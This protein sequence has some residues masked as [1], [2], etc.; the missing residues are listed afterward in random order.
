MADSLI[1][2]A[3]ALEGVTGA[4]ADFA[5]SIYH[6]ESSSGTNTQTSNAG[7][8][9]GMQI[10]PSTFRSVA[11][12]G[13]NIA[14]PLQNIRA[15]IRYA[16]KMFNAAKGDP[17]IAAAGYYGGLGGL[18][19]AKKGIAVKDPKNP[20][21]PSTLEY[22]QQVAGRMGGG[23]SGEQ[24]LAALQSE[25][26]ELTAAP[27]QSAPDMAK[28]FSA[29]KAGKM[30]K[31]DAT[32]F[33]QD[34]NA[35][36]IM[37]PV[38]GQL[39]AGAA[40]KE[41]PVIDAQVVAARNQGLM[42]EEDAL[43]FDADIKAGII[44][45]P[46]GAAYPTPKTAAPQEAQPTTL[47]GDVGQGF[48]NLGGAIV[49]DGG[50]V[51]VF[52]APTR[53]G[54]GAAEAIVGGGAH[55]AA[56]VPEGLY[57]ITNGI[58]NMLPKAI[59]GGGSSFGEGYTYGAQQVKNLA[60]K[61]IPPPLTKAG[62]AI[63]QIMGA[64]GAEL[65]RGG[66]GAGAWVEDKTGSKVAGGLAASLFETAGNA[67][68]M[69]LPLKGR[70]ASQNAA[71]A[72]RTRQQIIDSQ[73]A[74]QPAPTPAPIP[75]PAPVRTPAE[76]MDADIAA[77]Q[78]ER[79]AQQPLAAS[80]EGLAAQAETMQAPAVEVGKPAIHS[81][82]GVETPVVVKNIEQAVSDGKTYARVEHEGGVSVVPVEELSPVAAKAQPSEPVTPKIEEIATPIPEITRPDGKTYVLDDSLDLV[83]GSSK[84]D[85]S[86]DTLQITGR[87]DAKQSKRGRSFGGFYLTSLADEAQAAGYSRMGDGT[88]TLYDVR[89]KPDTKIL[90]KTGDIM[91][92]DDNYIN[93][94]VN[95]GYGLI[96]GKD[97]RGRTE[98]VVL[99]KNAVEGM[100]A[101]SEAAP[102]PL[103][104]PPTPRPVPEPVP[105]IPEPAPIPAPRPIPEVIPDGAADAAGL[106]LQELAS[107][108]R[109]SSES[110]FG[111]N[112][113]KEALAEQVALDPK[114]VAAAER[115]GVI[116]E[117]MPEHLTT[118]QSYREL[119]QAIK[120]YTGSALGA[121]DKQRLSVVAA[122]ADKIIEDIGATKDISSLSQ[123]IKDHM[124][125][126]IE[127]LKSRA[128]SMY[129]SL[130]EKI[131]QTDQVAAPETMAFIDERVRTMNGAQ[132]ITKYE[133][134][135]QAKLSDKSK[136]TYARLDDVRRELTAAK[137]KKEGSFGEADSWMIDQLLTR[138]NKD[139]RTAIETLATRNGL[140]G[141]AL[142]AEF[143]L[144]QQTAGLYK[145]VQ[146]DMVRLFG[147]QL[148]GNIASALK[149][150]VAGLARGDIKAFANLIKAIPESMRSEVVANGLA[151]AFDKNLGAINYNT[152]ANFWN[153]IKRQGEA[154]KLLK[155]YLPE[156]SYKALD[157]LGIVSES[158]AKSLKEN[159]QTGKIN[160]VTE[161]L[162]DADTM[163]GKLYEKAK[164]GAVQAA[165]TEAI[166]TAAGFP[167]AGIAI[168]AVLALSKNKAPIHLAVENVIGSKEFRDAVFAKSNIEARR[169]QQ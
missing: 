31:D 15:G 83:H 158:I 89:I 51:D 45:L 44:A 78:A 62:E 93:Q 74:R 16:T 10:T 69:G 129:D 54:F 98:Y 157:D 138:L 111:K 13:W 132:H 104:V 21:A 64:P 33:E 40:L 81:A 50:F 130:R 59:G 3:L 131:Q 103:P 100:A 66:Q 82:N 88:P 105:P 153:G 71:A 11:D 38:G 136:P 39:K 7:A 112:T 154:N 70:A 108:A 46:N 114:V 163:I 156:Q 24:S 67:A 150:G 126:T 30:T 42:S 113:A 9:G 2:K 32:S 65:H 133:K 79:A 17:V 53:T 121:A 23:Q 76:R 92:L 80:P 139:Q 29:Y 91:R 35:G 101:R 4:K 12:K 146:G 68:M 155:Q 117:L 73:P 106:S 125:S 20:N 84:P 90:E 96:V 99:D 97:V 34:V 22:G 127:E 8:T 60:E 5:K 122:K 116:D 102:A 123:T 128:S 77:F 162:K 25:Y 52:T 160:S 115:I 86:I 145:S 148:D 58:S 47:L 1:D 72:A 144:A 61:V 142:I 27:K 118:N 19:K 110:V 161:T 109:A 134:M 57:G 43:A 14:D 169:G 107:K 149:N 48:K 95:D 37:L 159:I 135:V 152:F 49:G 166:S 56:M 143:D 55:M 165:G 85:L 124:H 94:L 167:G 26:D 36:R 63:Q 75:E 164:A 140:D 41:V 6:Q 147:K 168:G 119:A 141:K 120:S 18:M 137:Y 151:Y 28:I 87:T